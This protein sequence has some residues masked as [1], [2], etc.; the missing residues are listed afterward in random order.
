MR[1]SR[2]IN[3]V[4]NRFRLGEKVMKVVCGL[5]CCC[6]VCIWRGEVGLKTWEA[7][8]LYWTAMPTNAERGP[9]KNYI[10]VLILVVDGL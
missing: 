8:L 9:A 1:I 2:G 6:R 10:D 7:T 4:I 3:V 5:P